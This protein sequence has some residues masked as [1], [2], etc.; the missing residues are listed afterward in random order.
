M[1]EVKMERVTVWNEKIK[2]Y[3]LI[4]KLSDND[5]INT[6]GKTEDYLEELQQKSASLIQNVI[7]LLEVTKIEDQEFRNKLEQNL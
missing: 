6:L 2:E 3:S 1:M 4:N 5:L 7:N